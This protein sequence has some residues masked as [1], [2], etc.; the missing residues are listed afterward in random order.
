MPI[1]NFA[2]WALLV[3]SHDGA[4]DILESWDYFHANVYRNDI[5]SLPIFYGLNFQEYSNPSCVNAKAIQSFQLDWG[6]SICSWLDQIRQPNILLILDDIFVNKFS[7]QEL[8]LMANDFERNNYLYVSLKYSPA[9]NLFVGG[10][11]PYKVALGNGKYSVNLQP[12]FWKRDY[13]YSL[14]EKVNT[15]WAFEIESSKVF[16]SSGF[17]N[18]HLSFYMR[19]IIFYEQFCE[20]GRLYNRRLINI[21]NK[22]DHLC[23][24]RQNVPILRQLISEL[25][26]AKVKVFEFIRILPKLMLNTCLLI[27]SIDSSD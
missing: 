4:I 10:E 6:K 24:E 9:A 15:P 7:I 2:E 19:K 23:L 26:L 22:S 25:G 1:Y 18:S 21:A 12:S 11:S 14:A 13:L 20:R 8:S 3:C 27:T 16:I 5:N 17:R